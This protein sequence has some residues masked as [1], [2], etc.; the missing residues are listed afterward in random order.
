MLRKAV[1]RGQLCLFIEG[2]LKHDSLFAIRNFKGRKYSSTHA[3]WYIPYE[4]EVADKLKAV[5]QRFDEVQ[6]VWADADKPLDTT[7]WLV[8]EVYT[9]TLR[10]LR[11]SDTTVKNYTIQFQ[12]F[13][14]FIAPL[15]VGEIT[16]EMVIRYLQHLVDDRGVSVSTQNQ[17]VNAVKFYLEHVEKNE[18]RV[19]FIDRPR[20]EYKL[21]TV[22]SVEEIEALL[23]HVT[24]RKHRF[25]LSL[26]YSSGLR[27]SEV[28]N[29]RQQDIDIDRKVIVVR[30]GKGAKDRV[31]LLSAMLVNPLAEYLRQYA[32]KTLLFEG[33]HGELYSASSVNKIIKRAAA[34][35]GISKNVSAHTL[36]HSFATHLLER[37]TDL[38]Y[39]QSLLGHESSRTTERYTHVTKKGF[40]QLL[41]PLDYLVLRKH[42]ESQ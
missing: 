41:S 3:R 19:Y 28:L 5:L 37:G 29:L 2:K 10:R 36:R 16:Q 24:N 14:E 20:K 30:G 33:Q 27:I 42:P 22:L 38:R 40:E 34:G 11:Y 6:C 7:C 17:A 9:E 21:P 15:T 12:K 8:P 32:P 23:F 39:I 35:A 26:I 13:L 31:T 18:R 25:L 4:V 1:H